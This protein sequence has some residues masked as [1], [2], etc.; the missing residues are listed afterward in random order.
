VDR[1]TAADTGALLERVE[2]DIKSFLLCPF[3]PFQARADTHGE[4]KAIC[5]YSD[6]VLLHK[7]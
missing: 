1:Y 5:S 4:K 7:P 6:L 2:G 3:F